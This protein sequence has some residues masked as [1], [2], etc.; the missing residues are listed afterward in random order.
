MN[1]KT[2]LVVGVTGLTGSYLLKLLLKDSRYEKVK[3]FVRRENNFSSNE[4]LEMH[5]VE[6]SS[7]KKY[8][9]LL[10]GDDLYCCLGLGT[11]N[12]QMQKQR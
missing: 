6:L 5:I 9:K 2:A 12:Q 8:A 7:L 3:I 1:K 10:R 4:K 11:V